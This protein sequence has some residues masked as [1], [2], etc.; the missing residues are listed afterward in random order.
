[1]QENPSYCNSCWKT[2]SIELE[3]PEAIEFYEKRHICPICKAGRIQ[4]VY[5]PWYD[6]KEMA[7][8]TI[9][10]IQISGAELEIRRYLYYP[11]DVRDV[12][13]IVYIVSDFVFVLELKGSERYFASPAQEV[14]LNKSIV[15]VG[16]QDVVLHIDG[17]SIDSFSP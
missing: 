15:N 3:V 4:Y 7:R 2:F 6:A 17:K 14:T 10:K 11:V 13:R 16:W 12:E 8:E 5:P 9:S 1:M